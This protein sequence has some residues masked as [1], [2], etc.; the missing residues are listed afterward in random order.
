MGHEVVVLDD[1]SGGYRDHVPGGTRFIEGSVNDEELVAQIFKSTTID[2][3][4]ISPRTRPKGSRI[5]SAAS[6][7]GTTS[8]A[9]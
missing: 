6:T 5:S 4:I 9:R 7:I 8:S 1:L 2:F 3:V